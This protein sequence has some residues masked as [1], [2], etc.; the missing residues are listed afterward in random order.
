[1]H[2]PNNYILSVPSYAPFGMLLSGRSWETGSGY[3]FG[4]NGK[5]SDPELY[6]DGNIYDYGFRI[7]NPCLG[8]FLS[9][10]PLTRNYPFFSPY[11]FASGNPILN[12]D[13]D[14]LEGSPYYALMQSIRDAEPKLRPVNFPTTHRA[15]QS[16]NS[17]WN[18]GKVKEL[19]KSPTVTPAQ[20]VNSFSIDT[21]DYNADC[22]TWLQMLIYTGMLNTMG[23]AKFNNY[24]QEQS[25]FDPNKTMTLRNHGSTG[26][27]AKDDWQVS[28]EKG[29]G[30][31][32]NLEDK[33]MK[34]KK[35]ISRSAEGSVINL[36]SHFLG[37]TAYGNENI[38]KVGNDQYL[39]Q[40]LGD[41]TLSMNQIKNS[42]VEEAV[43][44]G[45]I[46]DSKRAR[47]AAIKQIKV[48]QIT[49]HDFSNI[50]E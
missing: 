32:T 48:R 9:V 27:R 38:L 42:L 16:R 24:I 13:I 36:E 23:E 11:Q 30:Y 43:S 28:D 31:L 2:R 5:E 19:I 26:I 17:N 44:R 49:E 20:A 10:D 8:K 39:A 21:Q 12:I 34:A 6:E 4:F 14:G 25:E 40:G 45:L 15:N 33:T 22:G 41:G 35:V 1:M 37:G 47:K 29:F 46:D 3:R 18:E 7:Y 50:N